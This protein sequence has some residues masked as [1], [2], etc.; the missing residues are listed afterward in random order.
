MTWKKS[1]STYK[2]SFKQG[3]RCGRGQYVYK[4]GS[5]YLGCFDGNAFCGPGTYISEAE[6]T[7]KTGIWD[8]NTLKNGTEHRFDGTLIATYKNGEKI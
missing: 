2:G 5:S 1:G 4:N 3:N 8:N 7:V 6:E